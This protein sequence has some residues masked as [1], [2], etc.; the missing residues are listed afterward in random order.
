MRLQEVTVQFGAAADALLRSRARQAAATTA[1][2]RPA[3]TALCA[4]ASRRWVEARQGDPPHL[5]L[6]RGK[7]G[8][9]P[10]SGSGKGSAG[11]SGGG[12]AK[13]LKT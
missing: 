5:T 10:G 3:P 9:G 4:C 1:L 13:R 2:V 11:G 8:G 6:G 12:G 7:N